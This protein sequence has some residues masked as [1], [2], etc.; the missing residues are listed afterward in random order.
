M[1][2]NDNNSSNLS[3][4]ESAD[5]SINQNLTNNTLNKL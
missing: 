5:V 4:I 2:R 1:K 3:K